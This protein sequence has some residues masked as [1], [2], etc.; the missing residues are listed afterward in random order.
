[1]NVVIPAESEQYVREQVASGR[2]PSPENVVSEA[3]RRMRLSD[4]MAVR[5]EW[6]RLVKEI[7]IPW[8][9]CVWASRERSA[10]F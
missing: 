2:F 10:G 4:A 5:A 7:G 6:M 1:M 3:L 8:S 9:A